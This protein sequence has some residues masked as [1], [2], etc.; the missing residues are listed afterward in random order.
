[1]A[2]KSE[3]IAKLLYL[4]M[5]NLIQPFNRRIDTE[6]LTLLQ[7]IWSYIGISYSRPQVS[8][9]YSDVMEFKIDQR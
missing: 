5:E 2:K 6:M 7:S 4:R 1:M 9:W 8:V 3:N